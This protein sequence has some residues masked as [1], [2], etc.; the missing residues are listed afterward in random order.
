MSYY[1]VPYIAKIIKNGMIN[2]AGIILSA[3]HILTA[4]HCID[5]EIKSYTIRTFGKC[6]ETTN[7]HKIL[8]KINHL[9]DYFTNDIALLL[10]EPPINFVR[11]KARTIDLL[12]GPI[13]PNTTGTISSW[14][15]RNI[16]R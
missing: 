14:S 8:R 16:T 7:E 5:Q 3:H 4:D 2:C 12:I 6:S 11:S 1:E 10:I 15:P 13:P 9:S